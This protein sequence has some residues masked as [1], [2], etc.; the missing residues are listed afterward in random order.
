MFEINHIFISNICAVDRYNCIMA[1]FNLYPRLSA[2]C[3]LHTC[4]CFLSSTLGSSLSWKGLGGAVRPSCN[5]SAGPAPGTAGSSVKRCS[6]AVKKRK[7]C[8]LARVS[9]RHCRRPREKG[10][11]RS[12][13]T[14]LPSVSRKRSGL[15]TSPS[16]Q[17]SPFSTSAMMVVTRVL[18]GIT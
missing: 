17:W 18:A 15:N 6:S 14:T 12:S 10:T 8:I 16:P 13:L 1:G 7:S 3:P 2:V 11:Q 4:C 5:A 9:P